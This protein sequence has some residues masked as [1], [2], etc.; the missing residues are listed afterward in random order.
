MDELQSV[1]KEWVAG[2]R[3]TKAEAKRVADMRKHLKKLR[4]DTNRLMQQQGIEALEMDGY[5]IKVQA[6]ADAKPAE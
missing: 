5:T 3:Q 6:M 1:A 2:I 4:S